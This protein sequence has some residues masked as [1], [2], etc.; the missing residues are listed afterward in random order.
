MQRYI[1]ITGATR[2]LGH[3]LYH[4]F[5]ALGHEV[6]GCGRKGGNG[7][8][9]VDVADAK[10]V[11]RWAAR[12]AADG[13]VPDLLI[14]NAGVINAPAP[15]WEIDP[16]D[17]ASLMAINVSGAMHSAR[18][19]IPGMITAGRG[20]IVNLSSGWGRSADAGVAPYCASKW[21]VEGLP[22]ALSDELPAGLAAMTL[23]PGVID[24][25]MLR[26][27]WPEEAGSYPSPAQWVKR[28]AP[29]ILRLTATDN[30]KQLTVPGGRT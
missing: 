20:V 3:A 18:A 2:G 21:A 5:R 14:C 11:Q 1:V 17:F 30:G 23:N 7:I 24:T 27:C 12:L 26:T 9:A 16:E 8:D 4:S 28:A 29:F 19:F 13:F 22:L 10:A 15:L 25:D 6:R